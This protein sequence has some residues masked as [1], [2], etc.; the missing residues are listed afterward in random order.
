MLVL[1]VKLD[2]PKVIPYR[3]NPNDAGFDLRSKNNHKIGYEEWATIYTGISIEIPEGYFGLIVPRSGKGANEGLELRNTVGIIDSDYR[4]E[5]IC[6]IRNRNEK[7][8]TIEKY[9]RFAQLVVIP[10]PVIKIELVTDLNN[11]NRGKS[12]FGE[13]GKL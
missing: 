4:G 6:K 13:S 5:I 11:T 2:D 10:I 8:L 3:S 12:G 9:E 7:P 1:K